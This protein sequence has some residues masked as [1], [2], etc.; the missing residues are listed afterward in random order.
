MAKF[1]DLNELKETHRLKLKN[2]KLVVD[3]D[4]N[5]LEDP[6][7]EMKIKIKQMEKIEGY[8]YIIEN[9]R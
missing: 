6:F 8:N 4:E 5:P 1:I 2:K 3:F 9:K 7:Y